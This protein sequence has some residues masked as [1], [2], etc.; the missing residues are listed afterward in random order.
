MQ[1]QKGKSLA[2]IRRG[3]T[4]IS[5]WDGVAG[6][7]RAGGDPGPVVGWPGSLLDKADHAAYAVCHRIGDRSFFVAGRQL[8]LCAR[9]SGT[10][11]GALAGLVVLGARGH[12]RARD[13]PGLR[14]LLVLGL[15]FLAWGFDG[16]NS[17]LT[18]FPGLPHLYEPHNL[19]RL[20]TGTLEGLA[21]SRAAAARLQ[22]HFMGARRWP[23]RA[24]TLTGPSIAGWP[25]LAWLLLGGA[26]VVVDREQRMGSVSVSPGL[27]QRTD[28]R[29][30][31]GGDQ[32][33]SAS[34]A[35]PRPPGAALV[36]GRRAAVGRRRAG[37]DRAHA[38]SACFAPS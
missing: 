38:P 15:F 9:C 12:G 1:L 28:D 13:L 18:L 19:L 11:L 8:P 32:C 22:P 20:I 17:Y 21:I 3:L 33:H 2:H 37:H 16:A 27:D 24:Q 31:G 10:Y 25:D 29:D 23:W 34:G 6:A 4:T 5:G 14:Y 36:P 30:L 26:L 7:G 35:A